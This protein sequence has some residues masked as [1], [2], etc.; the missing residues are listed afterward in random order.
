MY[1]Y[2]SEKIGRKY[3]CSLWSPLALSDTLGFGSYALTIKIKKRKRKRKKVDNLMLMIVLLKVMKSSSNLGFDQIK[4]IYIHYNYSWYLGFRITAL[5]FLNAWA[6]WRLLGSWEWTGI[7]RIFLTK[8]VQ[9]ILKAISLCCQLLSL[10][11]W[12]FWWLSN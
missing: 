12:Y 6:P 9:S 5:F 2:L 1:C 8:H 11:R 10:I 4:I 3:D 7:L